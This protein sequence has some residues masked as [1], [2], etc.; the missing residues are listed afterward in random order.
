M[1]FWQVDAFTK[2]PFKGNPAAVFILHS[3]LSDE[4]MQKIAIEMNL[5]ESAFVLMRPGQNPLLRWFTPMSEIDLCGHATMAS[6]HILLKE[7]KSITFDT[8]YVGPLYVEKNG[9]G[10]TMDF[11]S[12]PGNK[13]ELDQIP[14][15]VLDALSDKRPVEA[16]QS[17]DLMLVYEDENTIP[18]MKPNYHVLR[19][20]KN[21]II[22]TAKSK[23]P[24]DF[25]SRFFCAEDGIDEDPVTG[26]A[27]STLAPYWAQKLGK[28][29]LK[30]Y[31]IS[32]R[33][34][35]LLLDVSKSKVQITGHAITILEG[36]MTCA[37]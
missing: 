14:P 25:I 17:R 37:V 33:G 23:G 28:D 16:Y 4:L 3:P 13:V 15:F 9:E 27:H 32:S 6:A 12:R 31:Q 24:Y 22:V 30:A 7:S 8:K 11:P 20:Y 18:M 19:E 2:E 34:G 1:K 26:S 29:H 35:E 10:Y 5:S 36:E 21:F